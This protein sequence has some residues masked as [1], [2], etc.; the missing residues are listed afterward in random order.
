MEEERHGGWR[1]VEVFFGGLGLCK[2]LGEGEVV[3]GR[4]MGRVDGQGCGGWPTGKGIFGNLR[5]GG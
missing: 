4:S 3:G 5:E 1:R 2:I